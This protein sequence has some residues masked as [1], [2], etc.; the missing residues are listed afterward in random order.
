MKFVFSAKEFL[1]ELHST[2]LV[3]APD[4]IENRKISVEKSPELFPSDRLD[5][6]IDVDL[7]IC[8]PCSSST[9]GTDEPTNERFPMGRISGP[10]GQPDKSWL[11]EIL[12]KQKPEPKSV[13]VYASCCGCYNREFKRVVEASFP[14]ITW[15]FPNVSDLND[16]MH[17]AYYRLARNLLAAGVLKIVPAVVPA[18]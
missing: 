8:G 13:L 5:F 4:V 7:V 11:H 14:D 12:K 18:E 10:K 1:E 16:Q 17:H 9:W 3:K 15:H 6:N 2:L